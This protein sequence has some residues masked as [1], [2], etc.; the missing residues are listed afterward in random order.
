MGRR[1]TR[2]SLPSIGSLA[3][4]IQARIARILDRVEAADREDH[5]RPPPHRYPRRRNHQ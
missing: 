4:R 3:D 5:G 1:S 2:I